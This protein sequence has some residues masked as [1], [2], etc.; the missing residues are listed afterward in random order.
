MRRKQK[1]IT[2]RGEIEA[3]LERAITGRV[4]MAKDGVP[5]VVPVHFVYAKSAV[6]FHC[7]GEGKKLDWIRANPNVCLEVDEDVVI[8]T[9]TKACDWGTKFNS[10]I[11]TGKASILEDRDE[12]AGALDVIMKKYSGREEKWEFKPEQVEKVAVVK[13]VLDELTG[14]RS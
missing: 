13:I 1:E 2:D 6:Y 9:G 11:G 8:R 7:A 10:V 12:K 14:K 4:G 5:Y 3:I